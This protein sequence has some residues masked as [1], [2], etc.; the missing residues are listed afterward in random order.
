MKKIKAIMVTVALIAS[1]SA[2]AQFSNAKSSASATSSDNK[3]WSTVYFEYSPSK[4]SYSGDED[5]SQSFTGLS[6]GYNRAFSLSNSVPLFLET[7]IGVQYSFYSDEEKGSVYYSGSYYSAKAN[8]DVY[9]VSANIPVELLYAWQ[10]P[11]STVELIPHAGINLRFNALGE[12]TVKAEAS[13]GYS[14]ESAEK[15]YNL[16]DK[17]DMESIESNTCNRFQIGW[18]VGVKARFNK[19]FMIGLAYG[20]DSEFSKKIN[21]SGVNLTAGITF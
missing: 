19:R 11:N 2:F 3:G 7:G 4:L 18:K 15:S 10:I 8:L 6:L 13:S 17:D 20:S 21:T 5:D 14:K 1:T 16:F 12:A 9:I